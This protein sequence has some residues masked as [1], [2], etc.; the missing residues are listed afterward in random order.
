M[1]GPNATGAAG[2]SPQRS[3]GYDH[4]NFLTTETQPEK[5]ATTYGYDNAG[6]VIQISDAAGTIVL[7]YDENNRLWTRDAPGT[8]DDLEIKYTPTSQIDVMASPTIASATTKTMFGYFPL[9]NHVSWR[10]DIVNGHTFSSSYTYLLNDAIDVVTYPSSR[11]VKHE[12]DALGRLSF[13]KYNGTTFADNFTF[14][15][16]GRL[17][18][19][20]TGVVN[21][22]IRYDARQRLD[23]ITAGP[24]PSGLDLVYHFNDANEISQI[25]NT[26]LGTTEVQTFDYDAVGRLWAADGPW[27]NLRW[28]YDPAGNRLTETRGSITNYWINATTQRLDSTSGGVVESFT[29][30]AVG[31]LIGDSRG[32]YTYNARGLL[33]TATKASSGLSASYVYDPGGLRIGRT[34]NSQTTY[35]VRSAGNQAISE[36]ASPCGAAPVWARDTIYAGGRLLGAVRANPASSTVAITTAT[37]SISESA[38]QI[39]VG[40]KLTTSNGAPLTCPITVGY[41][42]TA[43]T[44]T[45]G[46]D[47]TATGGTITFPTLTAS[48]TVLNIPV[49]LLPDAVNEPLSET[50]TVL[51]STASGAKLGSFPGQTVT[52]TDDDIAPAMAIEQPVAG[53]V[54]TP[55][56]VSGWAIDESYPTGTGIDLLHVYATPT[57]GSAQFLGAATYGQSRPDIAT[58][59]GD[60]RFTN[61]GYSFAANLVPGGYTLTV[62]TF[63]AGVP[64]QNQTVAVTV[65]AADPHMSLELPNQPGATLAQPVTFSGWAIDAGTSSG[66]GVSHVRVLAYLNGTGTPINLGNA[67]YGSQRNDVAAVYGSGFGPSGFSMLV[68]GLAPGTYRLEAQAFSA[69]TQTYNQTRDITVTVTANPG[70]WIDVPAPASAQNQQFTVMGW[71]LDLAAGSGTGVNTVHLWVVPN[72][73]SGAPSQFLGA[74]TYGASRPDVAAVHGNQFLN[75]GYRSRPRWR[76]ARINSRRSR[77]A[78]C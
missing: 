32:T 40:V 20:R 43:G 50:F 62:Y 22:T 59:Y 65:A 68:R 66:T 56:T 6:N 29:Y 34:V 51:L 54:R 77:G 16:N 19:Y 52:I 55:V 9:T 7:T 63:R 44:A 46:Q 13:I 25:D 57:G 12:Y 1:N 41:E 61:S 5:G 60:N 69:V 45:V 74:A 2:S 24:Q 23:R 47:F 73:G 26:R 8:A 72:P 31:R 3:W 28:S 49:Q 21:H 42:T 30:D 33:A 10:T 48:D 58:A 39:N 37:A 36:F 67:T 53:S 35:T 14:G 4:R 64:K 11:P 75:S 18:G 76:R 17:S 78:R 71:A 70:G 27:G 15:D 38:S